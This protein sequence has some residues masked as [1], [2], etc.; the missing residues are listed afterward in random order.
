MICSQVGSIHEATV[1]R[2]QPYGAFVR[3]A[4]FRKFGLVHAR[5]VR[6]MPP[7]A[8]PRFDRRSRTGGPEA[9]V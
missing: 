8:E 1:E 5:Q 4:G 9:Q 3:L 6:V 7:D 2:V